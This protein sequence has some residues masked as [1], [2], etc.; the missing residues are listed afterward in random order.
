M[1]PLDIDFF[2]GFN[3]SLKGG[4]KRST[5]IVMFPLI[6]LLTRATNHGPGHFQ[7]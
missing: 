7:G 3:A 1:S 4:F 5:V 2:S 6:K